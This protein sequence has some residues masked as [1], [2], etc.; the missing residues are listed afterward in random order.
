MI[1][2]VWNTRKLL[3]A[4]CL[5]GVPL[6]LAACDASPR[7]GEEELP[8]QGSV[9]AQA[10]RMDLEGH[11]FPD[12]FGYGRTAT[13]A[14]I[15]A[16]DIDVGPDGSGLPPGQGSVAAG[17][18]VYAAQ[19]ASCHGPLGEGVPGVGTQLVGRAPI[20][21]TGWNRTIGNYWPFAPTI[22]DYIRRS[23]PFDRPGSLTDDQVYAL[24]AYLL[25][26]NEIIP[27]DAVLD[28]RTL[29]QVIM[30]ARDR[31]VPDDR[32]GSTRVR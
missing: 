15:A 18:G 21:S 5:F 11:E 17:T 19:C 14:E 10:M 22:F 24:T 29:P 2:R 9:R 32:D 12:R 26:L 3:L 4:G 27:A 1:M 28:A 25:H 16:L 31:F 7:D 30:P 13:A 6:L 23:M 20:D 8:L